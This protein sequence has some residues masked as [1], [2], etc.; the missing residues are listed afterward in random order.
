MSGR[1]GLLL[2]FLQH[3]PQQIKRPRYETV[4]SRSLHLPVLAH[5]VAAACA[6]VCLAPATAPAQATRA[7]ASSAAERQGET[8]QVYALRHAAVADRVLVL[9]EDSYTVPGVASLLQA[10]LRTGPATLAPAVPAADAAGSASG[11]DWA[12]SPVGRGLNVP[13]RM[14]T[15]IS[16]IAPTGQWGPHGTGPA[17]TIVADPTRNVLL[18]RDRSARVPSYQSLI[19]ALDRPRRVLE[20]RLEILSAPAT[21]LAMHRVLTQDNVPA[22]LQTTHLLAR[23]PAAMSPAR[24]AASSGS[25]VFPVSATDTQARPLVLSDVQLTLWPRLLDDT[26]EHAR[27][28]SAPACA[29]VEITLSLRASTHAGAEASTPVM[30]RTQLRQVFTVTEGESLELASLS[31][32]HSDSGAPEQVY[33]ITP[34]VRG[35]AYDLAQPQS[36]YP[37]RSGAEPGTGETGRNGRYAAPCAVQAK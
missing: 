5:C 11:A 24:T 22:Y 8:L 9:G 13:S 28:G 34:H 35:S 12:A 20:L 14:D 2:N 30:E 37:H 15:V 25:P 21:R 27:P 32:G 19:S 26:A 3:P 31:Q 18:I 16:Q 7:A 4:M 36:G 17:F 6:L 29:R 23:G 1:T 10:L 33:R